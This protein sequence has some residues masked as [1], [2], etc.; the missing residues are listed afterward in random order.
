MNGR[1][2]SDSLTQVLMPLKFAPSLKN[3]FHLFFKLSDFWPADKGVRTQRNQDTF[4]FADSES[5]ALW[6]PALDAAKSFAEG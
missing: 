3:I 2:M 1:I 4:W 6:M 5:L